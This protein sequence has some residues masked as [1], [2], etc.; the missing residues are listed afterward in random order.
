MLWTFVMACVLAGISAPF[1]PWWATA[2]IVTVMWWL[3]ELVAR[4]TVPEPV[5]APPLADRRVCEP[6]RCFFVPKVVYEPI[7][8]SKM[9]IADTRYVCKTCEQEP[10]RR[11][12]REG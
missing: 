2:I 4:E 7:P 6:G 5:S 8:G 10:P 1:V 3:F 9:L 11:V 12:P